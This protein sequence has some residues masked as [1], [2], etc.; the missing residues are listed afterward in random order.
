[1]K[2]FK[3]YLA[4][5]SALL[6]IYLV[7]QYNKPA[8]VNWQPTLAAADKIPFGTYALRERLTDIFPG[9]QVKNTNQ[10]LYNFFRGR[11]KPGNYIIIAKT[12]T[13]TKADFEQMLKGIRAGNNVF[14][15]TFS[16][17]GVIADRLKF[18]ND[19]EDDDAKTAI[20]FTNKQLRQSR[21][22]KFDKEISAQ[23]FNSY[24]T[25]RATIISLNKAGN[26]NYLRYRFGKGSL[27]LCANPELFTNYSLLTRNGAEYASAALSYL[28]ANNNI[29]WDQ[30][31]NRD[32]VIDRSPLRAFF[33]SSSLQWA[34]YI[35]F[36]G[37][38]LFVFFE[39]KRRQR[40]IPIIDPLKNATVDFVEVVGK[41]YY[42]KRDNS[43]IALK[44]ILY[45]LSFLREQ[46]QLKTTRLD[47]EF[48]E[49]MVWKTGIDTAFIQDLVGY[50]N[51]I[52][53]QSKVTDK[54]L[55][56][57]NLLIEKFYQKI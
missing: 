40:I 14:I 32:I 38:A 1:M 39:I 16:W 4:I 13:I 19:I 11:T 46:Y 29:Y 30:F 18:N 8:P 31:Q 23:Y 35:S 54:E 34:F 56:E 9:A 48:I 55:I 24:D 53:Q 50:I 2:D 10:S 49:S 42:E 25:A 6:I 51:Y 43:N 52:G 5:G 22:Y 28:P 57:L 33:A 3:I 12:V 20:N 45:L 21:Y 26:A 47:A 27:L 37:L 36:W 7:I 15:T 17:N 41:V 44:K